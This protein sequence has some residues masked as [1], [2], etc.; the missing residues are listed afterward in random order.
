MEGGKK[1]D[2]INPTE[3]WRALDCS[4]LT[5][6]IFLKM[7]RLQMFESVQSF[8]S[9]ELVLL[10]EKLPNVCVLLQI[11]YLVESLVVKVQ[12]PVELGAI[13]ELLLLDAE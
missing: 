8:N 10:E 2:Q 3:P 11:S 5:N 4:T 9:F 6:S 1:Y 13:T 7:Q 12:P